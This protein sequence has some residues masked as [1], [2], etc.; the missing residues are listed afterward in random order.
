MSVRWRWR[1]SSRGARGNGARCWWARRRLDA[2][3]GGAAAAA[4]SLS[5]VRARTAR[6][7]PRK[8]LRSSPACATHNT[9]IG[10]R[11]IL[12]TVVNYIRPQSYY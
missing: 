2:G 7:P 1:C 12:Y 11:R 6:T 3:D 4:A 10:N 8:A 9:R 5:Q